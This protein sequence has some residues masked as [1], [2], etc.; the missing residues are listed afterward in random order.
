ML[1]HGA[2]SFHSAKS[3]APD[4][5]KFGTK[6]LFFPMRLGASCSRE[7]RPRTAGP[8]SSKDLTGDY[9]RTPVP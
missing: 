9:R 3:D 4:F 6:C 7:K 8:L 5:V 2:N 1:Q